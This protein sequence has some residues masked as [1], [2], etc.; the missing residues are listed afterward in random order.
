MPASEEAPIEFTVAFTEPPLLKAI[1]TNVSMF[2]EYRGCDVTW[3]AMDQCWGVQR[4]ELKDFIQSVGDGRLAREIAQ[5][6]G[7]PLPLIVIEGRISFDLN[8]NL[9]LSGYGQQFTKAQFLGMLWS[10]RNEGVHVDF[11]ADTQGTLEYI[12]MLGRWSSKRRHGSIMTRPG[13]VSQWGSVTHEGFAIHIM[14][15]FEGIGL[16]KAR[17]IVK[18]FGGLP[19]ALTVTRSELMSVP[20]I[21][22]GLA[23]KLIAQLTVEGET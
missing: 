18:F 8:G 12:Q 17:A 3:F 15:G 20:G 16:D 23:D 10:V 19:L 4:K 6:Q 7:M 14:Q 13:P 21:G 5:M 1:A 22:K 11:T 9:L 2:P